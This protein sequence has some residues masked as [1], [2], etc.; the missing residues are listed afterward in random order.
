M[1]EKI[2]FRFALTKTS[3]FYRIL[4]TLVDKEI[5]HESLHAVET[6]ILSELSL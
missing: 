1:G 2:N 4:C 3:D 5:P 6:G